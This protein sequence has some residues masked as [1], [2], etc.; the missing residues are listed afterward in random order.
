MAAK[1]LKPMKLNAISI[2]RET[3][4]VLSLAMFSTMF[5]LAIGIMSKTVTLHPLLR[6]GALG[7]V[8]LAVSCG[9]MLIFG[10]RKLWVLLIRAVVSGVIAAVLIVAAAVSRYT[11][12]LVPAKVVFG[13]G[14]VVHKVGEALMR[15]PGCTNTYSVYWGDVKY[16]NGS[17]MREL[18]L[19]ADAPVKPGQ[20]IRS[21]ILLVGKSRILL[22]HGFS[23]M[24]I[25]PAC[26]A[27]T[28]LGGIDITSNKVGVDARLSIADSGSSRIYRCEQREWDKKSGRRVPR[29]HYLNMPL[30]C[31]A[32]VDAGHQEDAVSVDAFS[33][34]ADPMETP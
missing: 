32:E 19:L 25:S 2:L 17:D 11:Y 4:I 18:I 24:R 29:T 12:V 8:Y 7:L 33:I 10:V 15:S 3:L 6:L 22:A 9:V 28:C 26:A 20:G 14:G 31:F 16:A 30:S 23:G 27:V 5:V 1:M 34:G 13:E 21:P